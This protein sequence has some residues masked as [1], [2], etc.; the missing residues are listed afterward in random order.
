MATFAQHA[1]HASGHRSAGNSSNIELVFGCHGIC[2]V[3]DLHQG[4]NTLHLLHSS[5]LIN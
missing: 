5:F 4:S 3:I 2:N 1:V